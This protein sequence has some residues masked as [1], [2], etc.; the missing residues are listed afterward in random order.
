[1]IPAPPLVTQVPTE[2]EAWAIR[3]RTYWRGRPYRCHRCNR[4]GDRSDKR[5]WL[6]V[7]HLG[8]WYPKGYEP[9]GALIGLCQRCHRKVH[10]LHD[11]RHPHDRPPYQ[12]LARTTIWYVRIGRVIPWRWMFSW[13]PDLPSWQ[14]P[15]QAVII[16]RR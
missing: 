14:P 16:P 2:A 9:D 12:Y 7:H 10:L 13:Q 3:R 1:M 6:H 15:N 4:R 5:R 8:Y 11:H